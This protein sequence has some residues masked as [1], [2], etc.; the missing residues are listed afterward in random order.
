MIRLVAF[1][2]PLPHATV[3]AVFK[4]RADLV[5]ENLALHH[6][7]SFSFVIFRTGHRVDQEYWNRASP[8]GL[9]ESMADWD[10]R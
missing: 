10:C 2:R 1:E 7:F 6:Q 8:N 5:A 3:A 9:S 4:D